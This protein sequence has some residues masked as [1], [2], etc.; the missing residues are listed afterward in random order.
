MAVK[1]WAHRDACAGPCAST[2][3]P[4][5]SLW[6]RPMSGERTLPFS[7][8]VVCMPWREAVQCRGYLFTCR[9]L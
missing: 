8:P 6:S 5:P 3:Q 4:E 9:F 1:G 7:A 2:Q